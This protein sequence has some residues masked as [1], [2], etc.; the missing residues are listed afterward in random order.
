MAI[1][2]CA[3]GDLF[4]LYVVVVVV[5]RFLFAICALDVV[6]NAAG[7]CTIYPAARDKVHIATATHMNISYSQEHN[8]FSDCAYY[9]QF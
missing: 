2:K 9:F 5:V 4:A 7:W 6:G 1:V 3:H 8:N